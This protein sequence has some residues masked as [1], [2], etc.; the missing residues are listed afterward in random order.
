MKA[1]KRSLHKQIW[2]SFLFFSLF[3]L[4]FL[5][6]TQVLFFDQYYE[7]KRTKSLE[8]IAAK[9]KHAYGS[10]DFYNQLDDLSY[11][12]GVCIE[13]DRNGYI[14][15]KTL[16]FN[17]GCMVSGN[18][19][20]KKDF[21]ESKELLQSYKLINQ[22]FNNQVLVYAIRLDSSTFA[23]TSVSLEPLDAQTKLLQDQLIIF[24]VIVL[25]LSFVVSYYLSKIIANPIE[26]MSSKA[27]HIASGE[28]KDSFSSN[29]EIQE[30]KD[31]EKSLNVMR[32]DFSKT[33]ELRRDLMA[34]VS[35]DLKTPLT[36][37]RAYA[38]MVRDLTYKDQKK[39]EENLNVIIEESDRLSILVDDILTLSS[40][41]TN[42]LKLEYTTF[43]L[44]EMILSILKRYH[45]LLEKE[46]YQF[47]YDEQEIFVFA[48]YKRTEQVIYNLINNAIQY[49]GDDK[50][51]E[52]RV[53]KKEKTVRIEIHDTGLGIP[54]EEVNHIWDKY[55]HSSK[56]HRRNLVGTG[57][58]L[59]IVKSILEE[60]QLPYG[61]ISN[62][63]LGTTFYFELQIAN[64]HSKEENK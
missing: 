5:W 45:V 49:T 43:S 56:K 42:S 11:D 46:N 51:V 29:S 7:Y 41:Q 24:S 35:H 55:Y 31:L 9:V 18:L 58:G 52:I 2:F 3:I 54:P 62:E 25:L 19:E 26:R 20:Y 32:E 48:D 64:T 4:V 23:Y 13:I 33:E 12:E 36:M 60:Y 37:I 59:S 21:I 30:I 14:A 27:L 28:Y 15:Y 39:R 10:A 17:R 44:N 38:E 6:L 61:V 8:K 57:L 47:L 50:K 53:L 16:S 63:N 34:N 40:L 1:R 22:K